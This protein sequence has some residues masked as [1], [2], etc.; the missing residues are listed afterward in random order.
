MTGVPTRERKI[1]HQRTSAA[2][3]ATLGNASSGQL[4]WNSLP[5]VPFHG[6]L[7][8]LLFAFGQVDDPQRDVARRFAFPILY[9]R[10]Q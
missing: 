6:A 1:A 10:L 8:E 7:A 4:S 2:A 3:I 9:P 5:P